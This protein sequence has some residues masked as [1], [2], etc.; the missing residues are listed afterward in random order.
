MQPAHVSLAK[1]NNC[2]MA[3]DV[4]RDCRDMLGGAGI[5]AEFA[6]DPSHAQ[7]R[8]RHHLRGHRDHPPADDRAAADGTERVLGAAQRRRAARRSRSAVTTQRSGPPGFDRRRTG[9]RSRASGAAARAPAQARAAAVDDA[10]VAHLEPVAAAGALDLAAGPPGAATRARE[11]RCRGAPRSRCC[12]GSPGSTL[13]GSCAGP[14]AR[15]RPLEP[16]STNSSLHRLAGEREFARWVCVSA[17]GQGRASRSPCSR[18][19]H[20]RAISACARCALR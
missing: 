9:S 8:E 4:A 20:A 12:H 18:R 6:P 17:H 13:A 16:S 10:H 2:R 15:L 19:S 1:W 3:L 11:R 5:S 7:S 14:N